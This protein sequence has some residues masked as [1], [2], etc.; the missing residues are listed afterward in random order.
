MVDGSF[1]DCGDCETDLLVLLT[2]EF[3]RSVAIA[4]YKL[5]AS[6]FRFEPFKTI[7]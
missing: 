7:A 3:L 6:I 4:N 5:E 2:F 1:F